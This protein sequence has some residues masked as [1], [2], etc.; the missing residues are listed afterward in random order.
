M[1][2][3]DKNIRLKNS[4]LGI[5]SILLKHLDT[6]QSV[7]SLWEGVK[8]VD[9]ITS[10]EKFVLTLDFLFALDLVKLEKGI[11]KKVKK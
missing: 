7:S 6:N 11:L 3:P 10:F 8:G 9:E 2:L 5:G 1:I 4:L